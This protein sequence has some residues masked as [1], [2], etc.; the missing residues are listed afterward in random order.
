[1][2][3]RTVRVCQVC[4][5]EFHGH[6]DNHYCQDCA[7]SKKLDTVLRIRICQDCDAKFLGG[8]RASRCQNCA[9]KAAKENAKRFRQKGA[10]R[11][12]GSIDKCTICGEDYIVTAGRQKYCSKCQ[13]IGILQWQREHKK[14]Y[15]KNPDIVAKK[16]ERR[17]QQEKVCIYCLRSFKANSPSSLCSD[18]CRKEQKKLVQCIADIKRGYNRD[19]KKY[20]EKRDKYREEVQ[21]SS[22]R[23]CKLSDKKNGNEEVDYGDR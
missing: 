5:K 21:K 2:I 14:D 11:P 9:E 20:E 18:Y 13:R 3:H 8:P 15:H 17:N 23:C 22:R 16:Q 10:A 7:K 19:L 1:M 12:L 4:G 6:P